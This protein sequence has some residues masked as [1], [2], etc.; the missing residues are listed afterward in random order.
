MSARKPGAKR[1]R[2]KEL[3]LR[4]DPLKVDLDRDLVGTC[5]FLAV[6]LTGQ[7]ADCLWEG[8]QDRGFLVFGRDVGEPRVW[9]PLRH[10]FLYVDTRGDGW[11]I[12]DFAS[13][14]HFLAER[15][16]NGLQFID[17]QAPDVT[18]YAEIDE[19]TI[20]AFGPHGERRFHIRAA[21]A[22]PASD[23]RPSA[24]PTHVDPVEIEALPDPAF[25]PYPVLPPM[26][27]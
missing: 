23:D 6:L 20:R 9:D 13:A 1:T 19:R 15:S 14:R 24:T 2:S 21:L 16:G 25:D 26:A 22:P 3:A 12:Y 18:A 8:D 7:A 4:G 5:A 11:R 17:E 10:S 27:S